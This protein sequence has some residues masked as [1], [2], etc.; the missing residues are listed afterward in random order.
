[1]AANASYVVSALVEDLTTIPS[2]VTTSAHSA[3][4]GDSISTAYFPFDVLVGGHGAAVGTAANEA[5]ATSATMRVI[6]L[7]RMLV[8]VPEITVLTPSIS[9]VMRVMISPWLLD[10][11]NRCDMFCR[12]LYIWLRMS[13]VM[14]CAIQ[15]L[16]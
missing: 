4:R 9:L 11:K 6:E 14:C 12:W 15:V 10:V 2:D 8:N 7:E 16:R 1:M 3:A 13:K 5:A